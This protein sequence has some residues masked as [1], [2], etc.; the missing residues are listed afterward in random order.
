M[1]ESKPAPSQTCPICGRT[2]APRRRDQRTC[3][4]RCAHIRWDRER[5]A[6][7]KAAGLCMHGTCPRPA[8]PGRVMCAEHERMAA[9]RATASSKAR[10]ERADAAGMCRWGGCHDPRAE[11]RVLCARHLAYGRELRAAR[12]RRHLCIRCGFPARG[13]RQCLAC[14][15]YHR[16]RCAGRLIPVHALRDPRRRYYALR[17]AGLCVHCARPAQGGRTLCARHAVDRGQPSVGLGMHH[18][19]T[20]RPRSGREG[21]GRP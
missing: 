21:E 12:A 1:R 9:R 10:G 5:R 18:A 19:W 11:G 16:A 4:D 6:R 17:D 13:R 14:R 3:S 7:R 15:L 8:I 20:L 2:Y